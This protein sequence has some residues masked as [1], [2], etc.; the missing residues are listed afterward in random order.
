MAITHRLYIDESGDHS[1]NGTHDLTKRY[2]GLT[3]VLIAISDYV[4]KAHPELEQL[5]RDH[6]RYDPDY[7]VI[8]VRKQI[9][10]RKGAFGVLSNPQRNADWEQSVTKFFSGL[11]ARPYTVVIDKWD[12][13]KRYPT[14][15]FD[16]Y[17]YAISV[18]LRRVRSLTWRFLAGAECEVIA[19]S[20][21][22]VEDA[23][24][25]GAYANLYVNGDQWFPAHEFRAAYPNPQ[26]TIRKKSENVSGHQIADLLAAGQK[27]LTIVEANLPL[28]RQ[29]SAF[30]YSVNAAIASRIDKKYQRF[31]LT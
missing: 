28:I 30:T 10:D 13:K 16:P 18:L 31:L 25:A 27:E 8:L 11:P 23:Q 2:L 12:H 21:G 17:S 1:Y 4:S 15:T 29:P 6:F 7:P 20:R 19:E 5:K 22:N 9:I 14:N 24:L 26:I 3:G